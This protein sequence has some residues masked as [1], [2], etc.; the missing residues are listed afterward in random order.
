MASIKEDLFDYNKNSIIGKPTGIDIRQKKMTL[1]LIYTL[2]IVDKEIK[3]KIINIIKNDNNNDEKI[4][5]LIK[6][7]TNS[8]GLKYAENK[9][10]Y[11]HNKS[12]QLLKE[13]PKNKYR[14]ALELLVN[15]VITR[16]K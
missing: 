4:S 3:N 1:P 9:M 10:K 5:Y 2:N 7:V 13:F 15:H 14:D 8:G 16:K 11:Y 12:L 6:L